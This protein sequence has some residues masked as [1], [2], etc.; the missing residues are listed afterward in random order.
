MPVAGKGLARLRDPSPAGG[1]P[2]RP[3]CRLRRL[4]AGRSAVPVARSQQGGLHPVARRRGR[5]RTWI[6]RDYW[7]RS[8]TCGRAVLLAAGAWCPGELQADTTAPA[9][10]R[11][12]SA[13]GFRHKRFAVNDL[14]LRG[15]SANP[16]GPESLRSSE[17]VSGRSSRRRPLKVGAP[18]QAKPAL[19]Q[20]P[21]GDGESYGKDRLEQRWGPGHNVL[22]RRALCRPIGRLG[23]ALVARLPDACRGSR[24]RRACVV[25]ARDDSSMSVK[26]PC[27]DGNA[28]AG[29]ARR[30]GPRQMPQTRTGAVRRH[31]C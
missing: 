24:Y 11:L 4:G 28:W 17:R 15:K 22:W 30:P 9:V 27:G 18:P 14:S 16:Q 23:A 25:P 3:C 20:G 19:P 2:R 7:K 6:S 13:A 1:P 21:N 26:R 31:A 10:R 8:D 5:Y 12:T 29:N